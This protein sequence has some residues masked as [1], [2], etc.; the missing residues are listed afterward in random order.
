MAFGAYGLV[1][2]LGDANGILVLDQ[3]CKAADVSVVARYTRN[4]GHDTVIVGGEVSAVKAAVD[5][6]SENP[7]CDVIA[8]A[9]ISGPSEETKRILTD[10]QNGRM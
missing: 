3:M 10:W 7:P 6:V 4:G 2:V 5:V 8:S 9:V 1:E